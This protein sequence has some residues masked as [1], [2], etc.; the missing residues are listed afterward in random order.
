MPPRWPARP[1]AAPRARSAARPR[2]AAIAASKSATAASSIEPAL[3][4][5]ALAGTGLAHEEQRQWSQAAK[6]YEEAAKSPDKALASWAKERLAAVAANGKSDAGAPKP[7]PKSGATPQKGASP[8][9]GT[10]L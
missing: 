10:K 4:Y 2:S 3:R 6:F 9:K 8:Q 5:R 1:R 7:L